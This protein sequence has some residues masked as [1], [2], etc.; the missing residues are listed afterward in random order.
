MWC[1]ARI[2]SGIPYV[3][4]GVVSGFYCSRNILL[5]DWNELFLLHPIHST[6]LNSCKF[7]SESEQKNEREI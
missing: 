4:V 3:K 5:S 2:S 6:E 1:L 7:T